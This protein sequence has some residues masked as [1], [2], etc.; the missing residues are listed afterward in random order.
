MSLNDNTIKVNTADEARQ[1][2]DQNPA[3]PRFQT[4]IQALVI[5]GA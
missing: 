5:A 3:D 1:L 4:W 2:A